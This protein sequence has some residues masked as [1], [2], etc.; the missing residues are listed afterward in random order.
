[1]NFYDYCIMTHD[2]EDSVYGDFVYD[3]QRDKDFP[4]SIEGRIQYVSGKGLIPYREDQYCKCIMDHLNSF[5]VR[6]CKEAKVV[7]AEL[8][9]EW[10]RNQSE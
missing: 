8:W 7:F 9:N 3:M 1:M 2:G 4:K 10:K 6:A 5:N